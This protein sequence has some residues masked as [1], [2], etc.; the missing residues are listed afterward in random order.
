MILPGILVVV[1][2]TSTVSG[3]RRIIPKTPPDPEEGLESG[4]KEDTPPLTLEGNTQMLSTHS[5]IG[6]AQRGG[7][8]SGK[9]SRQPS[10]VALLQQHS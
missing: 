10:Q 1:G 7:E 3:S 2:G 6:L 4:R 5:S 8:T 9:P